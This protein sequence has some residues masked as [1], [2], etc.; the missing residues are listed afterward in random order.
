MLVIRLQRTGRR[1][2]PAYRIVVAEKTA[3]VKGRSIAVLGHYLPTRDPA[4]VEC[5]NEKAAE[6]VK[7]GAVP[8]DTC[9]RLLAKNGVKGLEKYISRYTKKRPKKEPP[10]EA[11]PPPPPPPA[12]EA[13]PEAPAEAEK[14]AEPAPAPEAPAEAEAPAAEG[15]DKTEE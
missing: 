15:D 7:K 8:S 1:N 3:P 6:W 10:P 13:A 4:V 12:A 11:A 14:P 9:A 2:S 5:D